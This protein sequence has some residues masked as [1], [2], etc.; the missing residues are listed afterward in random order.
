MDRTSK[1]ERNGNTSGVLRAIP[2]SR[3]HQH[4]GPAVISLLFRWL[5]IGANAGELRLLPRPMPVAEP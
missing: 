5:S 1:L 4:R 3:D 2:A